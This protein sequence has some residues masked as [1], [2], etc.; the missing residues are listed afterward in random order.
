M[1]AITDIQRS[2]EQLAPDEIAKLR[3]WLD[4]LEARLF[5]EKIARDAQSGKL[6]ARAEKALADHKAGRTREL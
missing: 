5:D 2:I 4:E 1:S 3:D 6:D